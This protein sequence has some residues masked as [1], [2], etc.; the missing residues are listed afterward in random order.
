VLL[1]AVLR[2]ERRRRCNWYM[3]VPDDTASNALS[4]PSRLELARRRPELLRKP[5]RVVTRREAA[6]LSGIILDTVDP[7]LRVRT[8]DGRTP[9]GAMAAGRAGCRASSS[10]VATSRPPEQVDAEIVSRI[11]S[12]QRGAWTFAAIAARLER[13]RRRHRPRRD[14]LVAGD[15]AEDRGARRAPD[16]SSL[17]GEARLTSRSGATVREIRLLLLR[18]GP[19]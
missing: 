6:D 13:R 18:V 11:T 5:D 9:W 3:G 14:T 8:G 12:R 4:R 7:R 2:G 16:G 10:S 15:G 19:R 17:G 1:P